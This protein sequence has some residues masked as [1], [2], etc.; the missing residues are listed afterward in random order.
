MD[1]PGEITALLQRWGDGDRVALD[2]LTPLVYA[3]LH[4]LARRAMRGERHDHTLQTTALV[5]EAFIRL[6]GQDRIRWQTRAQF[7]AVAAQA[8]RRILVDEARRRHAAKRPDPAQRAELDESI[9]LPTTAE[10]VIALGDA[11]DRLAALDARQARV[12]ELKYF[13][14][15]ELDEI[16]QV[17]GIGSA[18][19][20][21]DWRLAR[22][23]L[24]QAL[25]GALPPSPAARE[26]PPTPSP[27][28][29]PGET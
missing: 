6:V 29:G 3:E 1:D 20:T 10:E 21:R 17:L 11:L 22:G 13:G 27:S 14:G 2:R 4:Q 24:F 16:A 26:A 25:G 7:A 19:V 28:P 9:E 12:V 15:M 8:M 18:T 5:N 23:W